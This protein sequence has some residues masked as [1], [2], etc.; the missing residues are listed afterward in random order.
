MSVAE[1]WRIGPDD[2]GYP[3][4][5]TDLGEANGPVLFGL[6][7]RGAVAGLERRSAVTIVGTR[8]PSAYGLRMAEE[9]AADLA[10]TGV[11]VVSGMA[12]GI[13]A[14]AHRGA[15]A[16]EGVTVAVLAG[17]PD[18]VYPGRHRRLHAEIRER[19]AVIADRAPGSP[20]YKEG[21][22]A[23]NRLMAA[24]AQVVVIVEAADPSGTLITAERAMELGRDLA[25]VPGQ[26][27]MRVAVGTNTRIK[28]GAALVRDAHD[29][30]DLLAGV[31]ATGPVRRGPTLEPHLAAA[32]ELLAAGASTPEKLAAAGHMEARDAAIA[33]A[34]LE[35]LGYARRGEHGSYA[36]TGLRPVPD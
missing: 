2:E 35:L 18:V 7:K 11:V 31:G 25:A 27:G 30:L 32:C 22:P 5:L 8:R 13:D 19:G 28:E 20:V 3:E 4:Q 34:R 33:L 1:P 15:L 6:G 9:L 21:F 26:V 17:G 10:I 14:A 36:P 16:A 29:V 23:R 24:L 12:I